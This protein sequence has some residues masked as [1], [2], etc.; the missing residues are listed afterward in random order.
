MEN[1]E[2]KATKKTTVK[3]PNSLTKIAATA[4]TINAEVKETAS[5]LYVEVLAEGKAVKNI[6]TKSVKEAA[7]KIHV[8]ENM[9]KIKA[10][11]QKINSQI[12]ETATEILG[13]VVTNR[14]EFQANANKMA[15]EAIENANITERVASLKKTVKNANDFTFATAEGL[16]D[17]LAT[18]GAQWQG[19]AN[20]AVKTGLKVAA[21]QQDMMF[22][23]LET[24]K[25]QLMNSAARLKSIIKSN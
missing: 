1:T 18:N 6:A 21:R 9:A 25:G 22:S 7:E 15:I 13:D 2:K 24:V 10:T 8:S 20:K 19:V 17:G 14:K 4:K 12:K 5:D 11:A 23:T 16:V 3:T